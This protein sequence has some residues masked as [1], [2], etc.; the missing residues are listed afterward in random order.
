MTTREKQIDLDALCK[1]IQCGPNGDLTLAGAAFI[2]RYL[3]HQFPWIDDPNEEEEF[4]DS[5]AD[6]IDQLSSIETTLRERIV[7]EMGRDETPQDLTGSQ[8]GREG[9]L[10]QAVRDFLSAVDSGY[11]GQDLMLGPPDDRAE[12]AFITSLREAVK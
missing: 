8:F 11:F 4:P 7:Y 10:A 2:L 6:V 1:K 3:K 12:S 5:G 9:L